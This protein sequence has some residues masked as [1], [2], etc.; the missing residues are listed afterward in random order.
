MT[1][2][3]INR[4]V[5]L[6]VLNLNR[7]GEGWLDVVDI[8]AKASVSPREALEILKAEQERGNAL[9]G[10]RGLKEFFKADFE[11][12]EMSGIRWAASA[13]AYHGLPA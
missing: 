9:Y 13:R 10:K 4:L 2:Q 1:D 3:E 6:D 11:P 12:G 7:E 8:A 5:I